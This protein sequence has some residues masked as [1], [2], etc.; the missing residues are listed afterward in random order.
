MANEQN[1]KPRNLSTEEATSMGFKG[2]KAS[3]EARR[4]RKTMREQL[5]LL[6]GLKLAKK[7]VQDKL[8]ALGINDTEID[9]QMAMQVVMFQEALKGN[10]KAYELIRDTLGERPIEHIQNL[11]PPVINIERP[12]E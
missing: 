4:R 1:L 7:D 2:G 12:K 10:T 5:E 6:M 3:G 9:N 8:K 11:N